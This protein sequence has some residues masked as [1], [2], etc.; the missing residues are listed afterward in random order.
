MRIV[1]NPGSNLGDDV[2]A[3]YGIVVTPQHIVVDGAAHDTRAPIELREVDQW[4]KTAKEFP[5]VVGTTAQY[6]ATTFASLLKEEPEIIAVMTSKKIIMSHAAATAAA[7]SIMEMPAYRNGK[8]LIVD[9]KMTDAAA[10]L[11]T[12]AVGEAARAGLALSRVTQLAERMAVAARCAWVLD[13]LDYAVKGG[14][15]GWLRA[16]LANM[17]D[18]KPIVGF[19]DGELQS[20]GRV[21]GKG[22]AVEALSSYLVGKI[23]RGRKVWLAIFHGDAV[24]KAHL[25]AAALRRELDVAYVY[26]RKLSPSIYLHSGAGSFGGAVLPI[27]DLPWTP[28]TPPDFSD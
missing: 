27:D 25:L 2:I 17:L 13:S 5:H 4:V 24:A 14:R 3:R 22:D 23:G 20:V 19:I 9:S 11:L 16:W 7:R 8:I 28:T 21:S 10:G 6:Y 18:L 15:A 1:T 26:L 12:I